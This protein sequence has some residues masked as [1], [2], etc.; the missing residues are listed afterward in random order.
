MERIRYLDIT[1]EMKAGVSKGQ[2]LFTAAPI[3]GGGLLGAQQEER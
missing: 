3:A 2:P 1:P